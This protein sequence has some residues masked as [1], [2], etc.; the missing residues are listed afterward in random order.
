VVSVQRLA[1]DARG[2][3]AVKDIAFYRVV[4]GRKVGAQLVTQRF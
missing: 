3:A 4:D 1:P 2:V